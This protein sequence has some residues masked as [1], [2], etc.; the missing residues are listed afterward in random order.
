[1]HEEWFAHEERVRLAVGLLEK[2][3]VQSSNAKE[4]SYMALTT[5]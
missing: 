3:V 4:V 5:F 1:M 2:P